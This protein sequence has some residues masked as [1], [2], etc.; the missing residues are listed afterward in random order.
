MDKLKSKCNINTMQ[1][2]SGSESA[3]LLSSGSHSSIEPMAFQDSEISNLDSASSNNY[4]KYGSVETCSLDSNAI[5]ILKRPPPVNED[6]ILVTAS[7]I[8]TSCSLNVI[9]DRCYDIHNID[10]VFSNESNDKQSQL[11]DIT[12][13]L[14]VSCSSQQEAINSKPKQNS[15]VTVFSI[16]NTILGSS[17]LTVPWGIEMAGFFP[18]IILVLL[19]SGLCLYTAYCLLLVHKYHGGHQGIEVTHLCRIYINKWA[20]YIAKSF[21]VI[22]LLGATIAYWVL[23]TNFLYNSVN[24]VYDSTFGTPEYSI[25]DNTSHLPEVLCLKKV[26]NNDTNYV[27]HDYTYSALGPVWDLYKTVPIF[28]GLLIFPFLNWNSPTFFTKFN[29]LGTLSVMYLIMFVLIK[30]TSW[31]IN[32]SEIE[33][34]NSWILKSSF[35][36]LSGMLALSFFIHNIIITIMQNNRDQSKNG[37]DLSIAYLLVTLTYIIVGVLFYVC[38]PLNKLCIED[39]FLNNF[40]KWSGLT[41]GARIVLLFQLLT[42]YPL[43]AYMLRVQLLS[44]LCKTY[45]MGCVIIINII[46]ISICILFAIF[47]PYIGTIIR[48][49][50]A[51]SGFI[52]VFTLPS[53]LYLVILKE[54]QKLSIF[55]VLLHISIPIFGLLNLVAQFFITEI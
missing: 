12:K 21:S 26:I 45:N 40:Q 25:F 46:L 13:F 48:Y 51:L 4:F 36:A 50:G 22:V 33:W 49:T 38:F 7:S 8:S 34:E 14:S 55:S 20:E 47:V 44:S 1:H 43:L 42:V 27:T 24:F 52:Y 31:G 30:S 39:N 3:H 9:Q 28:L 29:A 15:L 53:L 2:D 11:N 17:L 32:M 6:H 10:L 54:Q 37:R 16:W 19:M 23:M 5:A 18:G 41:V 35:P